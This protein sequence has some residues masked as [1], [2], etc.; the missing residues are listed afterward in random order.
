MNIKIF[1]RVLFDNWWLNKNYGQKTNW[2]TVKN[3]MNYRFNDHSH[4]Q[5]FP[6]VGAFNIYWAIILHLIEFEAEF[7]KFKL[8]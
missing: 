1:E 2:N 3:W 4:S 7:K 8:I 5:D 6:P